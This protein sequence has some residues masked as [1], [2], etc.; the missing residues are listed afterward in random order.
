MKLLRKNKLDISVTPYRLKYVFSKLK[1]YSISYIFFFVFFV[2]DKG[3]NNVIIPYLRIYSTLRICLLTWCIVL[4]KFNFVGCVFT[5]LFI[6]HFK[7]LIF[8][9][10]VDTSW[11]AFK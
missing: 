5:V 4:Q 3:E 7:F 1:F 10:S 8:L 11:C 9:P 6:E 2:V